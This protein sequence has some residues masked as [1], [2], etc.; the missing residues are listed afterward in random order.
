MVGHHD[1]GPEEALVHEES[2]VD[3][4]RE[5]RG[6]QDPGFTKENMEIDGLNPMDIVEGNG[7]LG[8]PDFIDSVN[9]VEDRNQNNNDFAALRVDQEDQFSFPDFNMEEFGY[10][11]Q[12][13]E[14]ALSI[15]EVLE[16]IDSF[17]D[18]DVTAESSKDIENKEEKSSPLER[19]ESEM[20]QKGRES[21]E[22]V[23]ASCVMD[24]SPHQR[25][26]E[27]IEAGEISGDTGFYEKSM[28][29]LQDVVSL[30][31][32]SVDKVQA[33]EDINHKEEFSRS[34]RQRELEK[35]EQSNTLSM[36]TINHIDNAMEVEL[37]K[38]NRN[39][40]ENR[41]K[42]VFYGDIIEDKI[43]DVKNSR[44]EIGRNKKQGSRPKETGSPASCAKN[45]ALSG[46]SSGEN[47]MENQCSASTEKV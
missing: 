39:L 2:L 37:R 34:E 32:N 3:E 35:D 30:E 20:Q 4:N 25:T 47:A 12:L 46:E 21:E 38:D 41:S 31:K 40:V 33:S 36:N 26:T 17:I 29:F 6:S 18:I 8:H 16:T 27:D 44:L 9:S 11:E 5:L 43:A 23:S 19:I 28:D 7:D 22:L 15:R 45:L 42:L 1:L 24:S 13:G 14:K 10:A